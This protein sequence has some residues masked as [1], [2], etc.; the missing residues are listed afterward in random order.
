MFLPKLYGTVSLHR[1]NQ[2]LFLNCV[3]FWKCLTKYFLYIFQKTSQQSWSTRTRQPSRK[4]A[5]DW[6]I[7]RFKDVSMNIFI[8][9]SSPLWVSLKLGQAFTLQFYTVSVCHQVWSNTRIW[10]DWI[11]A[12]LSDIPIICLFIQL[13]CW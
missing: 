1:F 3:K 11:I 10:Y 2:K 4:R 8:L 13:C 5:G 7:A 12:H 6:Y 9:L